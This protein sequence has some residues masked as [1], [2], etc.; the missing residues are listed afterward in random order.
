MIK[1]VFVDI[2]NTLLDFD[3]YVREIMKEGFA[4]F[5]LKPYEPYMAQVFMTENNKLW[6]RIECGEISISELRQ[7]RWDTIFKALDIDFDGPTFE[8]Y[9][10]EQIMDSAIPVEG[11]H[12]LLEG[13]KGRVTLCSASNGPYNQQMH[14]L[15][16][17]DMLKYFDACFIS[18]DIGHSKPAA[19]FF[20]EAFK[21]LKEHKGMDFKPQEVLMIGDSIS[22]DMKGGTGYGMKT[23]YYRHNHKQ[24]IPADISSKID[25]TADSLREALHKIKETLL[26]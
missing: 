10:V 2:D 1:A 16:K 13:L 3:A 23:C 9:F 26:P 19:E 20:D 17:A 8:K 7:T 24:P 4:H 5:G 15:G 21:R 11:A 6:N 18:D 12:E 25:M 14:R 22:S